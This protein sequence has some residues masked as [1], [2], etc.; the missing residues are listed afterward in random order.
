[1]AAAPPAATPSRRANVPLPIKDWIYEKATEFRYYE[2]GERTKEEKKIFLRE[3]AEKLSRRHG[4][5]TGAWDEKRAGHQV[6]NL[7]KERWLRHRGEGSGAATKKERDEAAAPPL[8]QIEALMMGWQ[9][10]LLAAADLNSS[11]LARHSSNRGSCNEDLVREFLVKTLSSVYVGVGSGELL[12]QRDDGTSPRQLDIV[13]YN[14]EF[15]QLVPSGLAPRSACHY[16]ESVIVAV[17]VKTTL[18]NQDL[19]DVGESAAILGIDV[20]CLV[21]AFDSQLALKGID[22][23]ALPPNIKGIFTLSHGC[24]VMDRAGRRVAVH[25]HQRAP[26]CEFYLAVVAQ[27]MAYAEHTDHE[28]LRRVCDRLASAAGLVAG[29]SPLSHARDSRSPADRILTPVRDL[30]H[31][32]KELSV[33]ESPA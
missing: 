12:E 7:K 27:M 16:R 11:S 28:R 1:M 10:Y 14:T 29:V 4:R 9:R 3:L 33:T 13:L 15:P 31:A 5:D 25:P 21:F 30:T 20:P 24:L 18:T 32:L 17:E 2:K 19:A 23:D 22:A 6:R 26:L 8:G